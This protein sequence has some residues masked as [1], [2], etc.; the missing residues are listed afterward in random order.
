MYR[1]N[2]NKQQKEKKMKSRRK[3]TMKGWGR[4]I[5]EIFV[6]TMFDITS[7]WKNKT[8]HGSVELWMVYTCIQ[9]HTPAIVMIKKTTSNFFLDSF[10]FVRF[11]HLFFFFS[12]FWTRNKSTALVTKK[13]R[14]IIII[15]TA[16]QYGT[17]YSL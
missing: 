17:M 1:R 13:R 9:F 15:I 10:F 16:E 14:K 2:V 11:S 8:F 4:W 12:H 5:K 6:C 3:I 7:C